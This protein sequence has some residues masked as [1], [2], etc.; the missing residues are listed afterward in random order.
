VPDRSHDRSPR[1]AAFDAIFDAVVVCA[2]AA[3]AS[4][5]RRV[6]VHVP[7][8]AVH[9]Y[10]LTA[11]LKPSQDP[12]VENQPRSGLMDEAYKVAISRIGDRVRLAGSAEI[13]GRADHLS[14]APIATL[15]KVLD[16]WFPTG[17]QR[18]M[19]TPWKGARPMLPD[20]P[21]IIGATRHPR[22]WLNLGHGSS[23]WALACGSARLLADRIAGRSPSVDPQGFSIERFG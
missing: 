17:A 11:P 14:P 12:L 2:G 13:G 22:L 18:S 19:A 7:L 16:D 5:L 23:G 1:D 4:L 21:P 8:L 3:S 15:Y 10:S 20:G 9:G 6:H